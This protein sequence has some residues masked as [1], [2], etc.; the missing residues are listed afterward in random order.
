MRRDG[1]GCRSVVD[2]ACST[3][4]ENGNGALAV[5]GSAMTTGTPSGPAVAIFHGDACDLLP[6]LDPGS[7]DLL[8]TSPPYWGHRTY[9][10]EH[11]WDI[12]KDWLGTGAQ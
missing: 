7:V 12:F 8:I 3:G 1:G 5:D 2:L 10:Q 4:T 6:S 9:E 11:N